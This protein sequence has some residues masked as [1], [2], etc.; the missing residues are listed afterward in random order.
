MA[1]K[2]LTLEQKIAGIAADITAEMDRWNYIRRKGVRT[3][4]GLM[5]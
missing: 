5:V 2:E 3:R 4:S 1:K